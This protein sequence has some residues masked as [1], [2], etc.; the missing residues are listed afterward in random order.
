[1]HKP[2]DKLSKSYAPIVLF[3]FDRPLHAMTVIKNL[4]ESDLAQYSDLIV[5][6]DY[7]REQSRNQKIQVLRKYL[8]CV[9]QFKSLKIIER[10]E[11]YGLSNSIILG[12]NEVLNL[13]EKVIVLEDDLIPSKYFLEY[14]NEALEK[15]QNDESV[16]CIHG[17]VYPVQGELP[18]AFF[19]RGADCWGWGT[20][21][22]SW[23]IFNPD[24]VYLYNQLRKKK[25]LK[26]FNFGNT[27]PYSKMLLNQSKG[28]VDS[29][30][31]RWYASAFLNNKKTLYPGK[32]L[33]RNIGMDSS[34]AHCHNTEIFDVDLHQGNIDISDV[35][36]EIST[37]AKVQF[38]KFFRRVRINRFYVALTKIK[39]STNFQ[40]LKILVKENIPQELRLAL[41][42]I[43]KRG[44]IFNG[45]YKSWGEARNNSFGYDSPLI[46]SKVLFSSLKVKSGIFAYERDSVLFEKPEYDWYL[47]N[48]LLGAKNYLNNELIVLDFGGSL[49]STFFKNKKIFDLIGD[50]HWN[51]VEQ[52]NFVE[53]GNKF[54][55]RDINNLKFYNSLEQNLNEI[56]PNFCLMSSSLQYIEDYKSVLKII[57]SSSVKF[58]FID[59]TPFIDS[60]NDLYTVQTV[61][62]SIYKA[63]YPIRIFSRDLFDDMMRSNWRLEDRGAAID[64]VCKFH[65]KG[66][67]MYEW[68]YYVR[69]S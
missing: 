55:N 11:N 14:M 31:I 63:S 42:K 34:G 64:E 68:R 53:A 46:L 39:K 41:N 54:I 18:E 17:Y 56:K 32:S 33:I 35:S 8:K 37:H 12:I 6:S 49:G 24:G 40:T 2:C 15:Y 13:Y 65:N 28:K 16:A 44:I 27:Y 20:W 59:R 52:L 29:W 19:L 26:E 22:D 4:T 9:N 67:V 47:I 61:P 66:E 30:A 10:T 36:G 25:L 60:S 50:I 3:V 62:P 51:I 57:E 5:Y 21:R 38:K 48:Y 7:S 43:F 23:N 45:L 58:L 69:N 1:M